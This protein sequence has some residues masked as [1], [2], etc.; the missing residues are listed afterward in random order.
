MLEAHK[1]FVTQLGG[2]LNTVAKDCKTQI[3]FNPSVVEKYHLIGFENKVLSNEEFDDE[4]S[5]AGEIGAGHTTIC[6]VELFLYDDAE[7]EEIFKCIV[8]YKN[9]LNNENYELIESCDEIADTPSIDFTFASGVVEFALILRQSEFRGSASI[10]N[11]L[12]KHNSQTILNDA[13]RIEFYDLVVKMRNR[14]Q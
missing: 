2:T 6:L 14:E 5:D 13:Y 3:E 1:V 4:T 7:E 8:R 10:G 11:N 12:E 9:P